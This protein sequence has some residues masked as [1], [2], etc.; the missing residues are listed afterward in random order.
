MH[1]G[2][3]TAHARVRLVS[4]GCVPSHYPVPVL[5][6]STSHLGILQVNSQHL[7]LQYIVSNR[8]RRSGV[9]CGEHTHSGL[10]SLE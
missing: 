9:S 8:V 10:R 7:R 3:Q 1:P 5:P 6:V 4:L 2:T